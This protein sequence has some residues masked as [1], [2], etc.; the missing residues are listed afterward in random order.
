MHFSTARMDTHPMSN[1]R[2]KPLQNA[3]KILAFVATLLVAGPAFSAANLLYNWNF[4]GDSGSAVNNSAANPNALGGTLEMRNAVG[5][6]FNF[7]GPSGSG[8]T[9]MPG[10]IAFDAS[11]GSLASASPV[12]ISPTGDIT[13]GSM[14]KITITGWLKDTGESNYSDTNFSRILTIGPAGYDG[15]AGA[16][17]ANPAPN[18]SLSLGVY[19]FGST[20]G[21][22][23]LKINGAG[24]ANSFDG[25]ISSNEVLPSNDKWFFF[26]VTYDS[27]API[28]NNSGVYTNSNA[29]Q[30][31]VGMYIGSLTQ[32]ISAP[33]FS[34]AYPGITGTT[35]SS[36]GAIQF[37]SAI[38]SILNRT[39]S[40]RNQ[41][42]VGY[43]DD[44]RI[45]DGILSA[46]ELNTLRQSTVPITPGDFNLDGVVDAAD[47]PAMLKAV[48]N[49][50][51][52]QAD[53]GLSD[54]AFKFLGDLNH[55]TVV[56]NTD[57]QNLIAL[58][59]D[60]LPPA[61]RGDMNRDGHVTNAD[62]PLLLQALTDLEKYRTDHTFGEAEF[63]TMADAN[64]DLTINQADI[65]ALEALIA[66]MGGGAVAVPEPSVLALFSS[67]FLAFLGFRYGGKINFFG[68][69]FLTRTKYLHRL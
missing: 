30:P 4:N 25:V 14:S 34:A 2:S 13:T 54:D 6:P 49:L 50:P 9:G 37:T 57:I 8:S 42:Y 20:F 16:G 41:P 23:Q 69:S 11:S 45:Y 26:A 27:T 61:M 18:S 32:D 58:I 67:A 47:L 19:N 59:R 56:T 5:L 66:S 38:A 36:P 46:Q 53:H 65:Q 31:T 62:L 21:A 29:S 1:L 35:P 33:A 10:D 24:G 48:T 7:H 68:F 39:S 40:S 44:F 3:G 28:V 17:I 63:K 60:N 52:Y 22:L 55:D 51:Q 64:Q 15:A 43:A 12:A